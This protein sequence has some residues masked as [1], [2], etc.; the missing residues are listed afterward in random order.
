MS[1]RLRAVIE[2]AIATGLPCFPC[3]ADKA[4]AIPG[5]GGFKHAA[6]E[7]PALRTLFQRY[8]GELVGVPTGEASGLSVLDLD[9]Y[10]EA[11]AWLAMHRARLPATRVHRT[12]SG[13]L[14]FVFQH[15]AG[16]RNTQ[17]RLAKGVDTRGQG[18]Y[19]VWWPA[20][21][22]PVLCDAPPAR[23]GSISAGSRGCSA[24]W[25]SRPEGSAT[26]A[27]SGPPAGWAKR[28]GRGRSPPRSPRRRCCARHRMPACLKARRGAR[29]PA[30]SRQVSRHDGG[31]AH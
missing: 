22:Y 13:G 12:K 21:G 28:S 4:P 15:V 16:V 20:A 1:C 25:F 17:G 8:P 11:K 31:I 14:H 23:S 10:P 30:A 26:A 18:G 29:S 24:D 7:P 6:A 9:K 19:A 2:A 27:C 3:H 5:P